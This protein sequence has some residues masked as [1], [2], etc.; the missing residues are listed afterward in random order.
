[1]KLK[2]KLKPVR[3]CDTSV[4]TGTCLHMLGVGTAQPAWR[5]AP[6]PAVQDFSLLHGV[7]TGSVRHLASYPVDG[8]L[9]LTPGREADHS[10]P[11]NATVKKGGAIPPL[12][13][14]SWHTAWLRKHRDNFASYVPVG[15][16]FLQEWI[17]TC[18]PLWSSGQ[19]SWLQNGD[20]LCFLWGTNWIYMLCRRK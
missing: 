6:F 16:N 3:S 18:P 15:F 14:S 8:T 4:S 20:V 12:P 5:L 2:W 13:M 17:Y 11:P 19:S 10:S 7:Q 9:S 1:V